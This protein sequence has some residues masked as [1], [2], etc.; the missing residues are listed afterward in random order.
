MMNRRN[1]LA[2][3]ALT[4]FALQAQ[5]PEPRPHFEV[6]AI[7]PS[8]SD[9]NFGPHCD[10]DGAS[11]GRL[12]LNCATVQELIQFAYGY[13]ANGL[14][15]I[16]RPLE[17]SGG[18]AW[19]HSDRFDI[20]AKAEG[21]A[22]DEMMA[23]PMLQTLLEDRF[24]LK[25]HREVRERPV[26]ALTVAKGGLKLQPLKHACHLPDP[27]GI[28]KMRS[29]GQN[30]TLDVH[31]MSIADFAGSL[32]LD[33]PV[34]DKTGVAGI[35]DFH[36]EFVLDGATPGNPFGTHEPTPSGDGAGPSIFTAIQKL[37]LKLEPAKGPVE[38]LVIDYVEKPSGN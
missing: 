27:C 34:L 28:A 25:V 13:Y 21:N 4:A 33:R 16:P 30:M 31:A 35:F 22:S 15:P 10:G 7:R 11:P 3:A 5:S 19:I 9:L 20:E 6:A 32:G 14:T 36:L 23:G 2:A 29:N 18:P 8:P 1:I 12:I 38:F 26:Y 24:K 37:G 17:I